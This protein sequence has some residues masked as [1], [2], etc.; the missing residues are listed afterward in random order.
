MVLVTLIIGA[1]LVPAYALPDGKA[2]IIGAFFEQMCV[3]GVWGVVPIH[4]MELSPVQIR[5]FVVGVSYQLGNLISSVSSTIEAKAGQHFRR[6]SLATKFMHGEYY[7]YSRVITVF[8]L[9]VYAYL[10][11]IIFIG[12]EK[13]N[14]DET[15][16]QT[17]V[18]EEIQHELEKIEA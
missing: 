14:T 8:L 7:D 16:T 9:S 13:R 2:I 3:Q 12:P 18:K 10:F 4:L 17:E 1:A 15:M 5:S 11:I 6:K